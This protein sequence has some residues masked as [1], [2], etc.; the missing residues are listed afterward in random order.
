MNNT[1]EANWILKNGSQKIDYTSFPYAYR[2]AF[3]IVRKSILG[4][5]PINTRDLTI[6]G[7]K[8]PRGDRKIYSYDEATRLATDM[9]LLTPEGQINGKEFKRR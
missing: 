4:K 6:Q 8:D 9:G 1:P 2:T 3:N 7:P 5:K